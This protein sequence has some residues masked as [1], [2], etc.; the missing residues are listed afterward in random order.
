MGRVFNERISTG[1]EFGVETVLVDIGVV[2]DIYYF[3]VIV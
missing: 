3:E 1:V 2:S